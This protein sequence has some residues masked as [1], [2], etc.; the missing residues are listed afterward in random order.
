MKALEQL[1]D[2]INDVEYSYE[3][4]E[5]DFVIYR[6]LTDRLDEIEKTMEEEYGTN[7]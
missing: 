5:M 2:L 1:E 3:N 4:D 6:W 7:S